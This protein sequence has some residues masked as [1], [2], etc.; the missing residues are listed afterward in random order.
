MKTASSSASMLYPHRGETLI[1][2]KSSA[3]GFAAL[4]NRSANHAPAQYLLC[5]Y[6][7]GTAPRSLTA[8]ANV[9]KI[10]EEHLQGRYELDIIDLALQPSV[11]K[12]EQIIAAPTLIKKLP[13]P[14]RRFVGDMS[15]TERIL[16]GLDLA[17]NSPCDRFPVDNTRCE[18]IPHGPRAE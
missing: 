16:Q 18:S 11:A 3:N 9:R 2:N 10:C 14:T 15:H 6:I 7:T 1:E 13:L 8:I 17:I 12:A 5:L 4:N